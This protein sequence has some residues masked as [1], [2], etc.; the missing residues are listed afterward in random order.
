MKKE[1]TIAIVAVCGLLGLSLSA[2]EA[3]QG[4]DMQDCP[5]HSQS[6]S[7]HRAAMLEHGDH[8]MGFSH[9]TTN[10]HFRLL[11]KG[12]AVEVSA[13]ET[14]D[15]TNVRAIRAHLGHIANSFQQGDFTAP[16][17]VHEEL[18]PGVTT[19]KLL[20]TKIQFKFEETPAGARVLMTSD[21]PVAVAAIQ[22]FLRYQIR[23]HETGDSEAV[24]N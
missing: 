23:E 9:E 5:M 11:A 24:P 20:A 18:P 3:G 8:V 21:D 12:G 2:Q 17:S 10:H 14:K 4:N 19:M 15:D 1:N 7:N 22:D 13:N 6:A 16:M